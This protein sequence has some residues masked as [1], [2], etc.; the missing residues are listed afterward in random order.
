MAKE[1]SRKITPKGVQ[2]DKNGFENL[3]KITT[4][5]PASSMFS[6]ANG[7]ASFNTM[8]A[9]ERALAVAEKALKTARDESV[10]AEWSFHNYMLG[11]KDQIIAQF[12]D[13]SNEIQTLGVKKK[14]EYK[15]P[16]RK[17]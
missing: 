3:K 13:D 11:A 7:I 15:R 2:N 4:Y 12:G 17:K 8:D 9:K 5:S 1:Q 16:A 14:S 6:L 10:A